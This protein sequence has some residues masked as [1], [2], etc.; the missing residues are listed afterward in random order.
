MFNEIHILDTRGRLH[1]KMWPRLLRSKQVLIVSDDNE[2]D[3]RLYAASKPATQQE[4]PVGPTRANRLK[5]TMSHQRI[6][7]LAD[8]PMHECLRGKLCGVLLLLKIKSLG[9]W[10]TY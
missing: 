8:Q 6:S 10:L 5:F 3:H 2:R 7:I 4:A 1:Y 9:Y